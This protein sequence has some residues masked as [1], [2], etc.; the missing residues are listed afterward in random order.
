MLKRTWV[1]ALAVGLATPLVAVTPAQATPTVSVNT[2]EL[3]QATMPA[4]LPA[5]LV[6]DA[7]AVEAASEPAPAS[8]RAEASDDE[9]PAVWQVAEAEVDA[10]VGIA[11][12]TWPE[13]TDAPEIF[14]RA[15]RAGQPDEWTQL[16]TN[17]EDLT[18]DGSTNDGSEPILV[19]GAERV[20]VATFAAEPVEAQLQVYSSAPAPAMMAAASTSSNLA[21]SNPDILSRKAWG[22][23]E[24]IVKKPYLYGKVTG[25]MIHYTAGSNTYSADDVPA[26][27][28]SIQAYH[29]NGRGW[30]DIGY[31]FLVDRFGR[32]WEGR[33]GGVD[34]AVEGGHAWGVT[35]A[36]VFGISLMG[37]YD[38]SVKPPKAAIETMQRVIAWKFKLH[39]VDPLG[40][41]WG[42]GGQAGGSTFLNAISGHRDEKNTLCP[43]DNVYSQ[44]KAIRLA[45]KALMDADAAATPT[46]ELTALVASANPAITG[47]LKVGQ[48]VKA[49]VGGWDQPGVKN[50][51]KW[52]VDGKQRATASSYKLAAKD[53]GLP[54]QL[55]VTG[56]LTGF[57]STT[58]KSATKKVAKLSSKISFSTSALKPKK[59][60]TATVTVTVSGLV[61]TGTVTVYANGKR[62]ATGKLASANKG[63][64]KIKLPKFAKGTVKIKAKY[65]GS[66]QISGSSSATKR[67]RVR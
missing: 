21:W 37:T 41:T 14:V 19:S 48:T 30:K 26:I 61:P 67:I 5:E 34:K 2:A 54:L 10:D 45:V 38:G 49:S 56:S 29:V 63:R 9:A 13:G 8:S 42:S 18:A 1:I 43:G 27:L 64:V 39:G 52:L 33:G 53:A 25:A 40:T 16:A 62:V 60:G 65:S 28:R 23:N 35:N 46:P 66:T 6:P 58:V 3:E 32:A 47:T 22:A 50:A 59:A 55:A 4:D 51:Y 12:V 44:M 57:K 17:E 7:S 20:Q 36:R 11:A 15:F 24:S 31:N